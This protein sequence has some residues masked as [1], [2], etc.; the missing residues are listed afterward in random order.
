MYALVT[1]GSGARAR[2]CVCVC[3]H[4]WHVCCVLA[5]YDLV[6]VNVQVCL[7]CLCAG[8]SFDLKQLK[9]CLV[10]ITNSMCLYCFPSSELKVQFE[11]TNIWSSP[12]IYTSVH[13]LRSLDNL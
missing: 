5:F 4:A 12:N 13:R 6:V 1:I 2:A 3:V 11:R 8:T 9:L 7:V 10:P